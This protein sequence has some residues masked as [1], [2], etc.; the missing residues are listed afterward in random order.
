MVA[1]L[2]R[3]PLEVRM[4]QEAGLVAL[5]LSSMVRIR[6]LDLVKM[7][8]WEQRRLGV[9]QLI[10]TVAMELLRFSEQA[11]LAGPGLVVDS[12]VIRMAQVV[13][14]VQVPVQVMRMVVVGAMVVPPELT[15][16]LR[17]LL[18]HS[19]PQA[20]EVEAVVRLTWPLLTGLPV[21]R[22]VGTLME[23]PSQQAAGAPV[24]VNQVMSRLP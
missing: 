9:L 2:D 4:V 13:L 7:L 11:P 14:E 21:L 20:A 6:S 12:L 15:L 8:R 1:G 19:E 18:Q 10:P 5:Y 24:P 22:L 16:V 3:L 17:L 23:V